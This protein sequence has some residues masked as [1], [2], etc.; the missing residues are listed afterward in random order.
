MLYLLVDSK[1]HE[2]ALKTILNDFLLID[3]VNHRHHVIKGRLNDDVSIME[4]RKQNFKDVDLLS[5][6]LNKIF[7]SLVNLYLNN[8]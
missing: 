2:I 1:H 6:N 4:I 5:S 8:V 3:H 7:D